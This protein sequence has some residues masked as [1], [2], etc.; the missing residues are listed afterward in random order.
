ME[1]EGLTYQGINAKSQ[2]RKGAKMIFYHGFQISR[3]ENLLLHIRAI[4]A[5]RGFISLVAPLRLCAFA[6]KVFRFA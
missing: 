2:R 5:I 4:R 1:E 6:L 3:M